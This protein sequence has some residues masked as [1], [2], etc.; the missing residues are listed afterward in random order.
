MKLLPQF[1]KNSVDERVPSIEM[2]NRK[3]A[4]QLPPALISRSSS[5]AQLVVKICYLLSFTIGI[6]GTY[7]TL[8]S[9][10]M[11]DTDMPSNVLYSLTLMSAGLLLDAA[12]VGESD[13]PVVP[14]L[15][16]INDDLMD[17]KSDSVIMLDLKQQDDNQLLS[18]IPNH[19]KIDQISSLND[20]NC[21]AKEDAKE[22]S[23]ARPASL[24]AIQSKGSRRWFMIGMQIFSVSWFGQAFSLFIRNAIVESSGSYLLPY[25]TLIGL[26]TGHLFHVC[27]KPARLW[28]IRDWLFA[29]RNFLTSYEVMAFIFLPP[30]IGRDLSTYYYTTAAFWNGFNLND[31]TSSI[32]KRLFR[33]N[34][35]VIE[36]DE[37]QIDQE[38]QPDITFLRRR[39]GLLIT[40]SGGV[41]T[42]ASI[43]LLRSATN[44]NNSFRNI[45]A[46]FLGAIGCYLLTY[47]LGVYLG[48]KIPPRYYKNVLETCTYLLIPLASPDL[49][50]LHFF[51]MVGGGLCGGI[52][53]YIIKSHYRNTLMVMRHRLNDIEKLTAGFPNVIKQLLE[54]PFPEDQ[55]LL[56]ARKNNFKIRLT[57]RLIYLIMLTTALATQSLWKNYQI[58]TTAIACA[59]ILPIIVDFLLPKYSPSIYNIDE[60]SRPSRL[61]YL[62]S[63]SL[64]YLIKV[65]AFIGLQ[66]TYDDHGNLLTLQKVKPP[67]AIFS[68]NLVYIAVCVFASQLGYRKYHGGYVPYFPSDEEIRKLSLLAQPKELKQH[69]SKD[70]IEH[71]NQPISLNYHLLQ[72]MKDNMKIKL[73]AEDKVSSSN[74]PEHV[75][76]KSSAENFCPHFLQRLSLFAI[77]KPL[78]IS[79]NQNGEL[80]S[81]P[82]ATF[83]CQDCKEDFAQIDVEFS[84]RSKRYTEKRFDVNFYTTFADAVVRGNAV[85]RQ[86]TFGLPAGLSLIDGV[87]SVTI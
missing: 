78:S 79:S 32:T 84:I 1:K 22:I 76:E 86:F 85:A 26:M 7:F 48:H 62:D 75:E 23:I 19:S 29:N 31:G 42:S 81:F 43:L 52:S 73:A 83:H 80:S 3:I 30:I 2:N 11:E 65:A 40:L 15:N 18:P 33:K 58:N 74:D 82:V 67:V 63:F 16:S 61:F 37:K 6:I 27:L 51:G 72:F 20:S 49:S 50:I 44:I 68:A 41:L 64:M 38:N 34:L 14:L 39:T 13:A 4:G 17:K 70:T 66:G 5:Y 24:E 8:R 56:S 71:K 21:D 57:S 25:T 87:K 46:M 60:M 9:Q 47:P 28:G 69:Y 54:L 36:T 10:T 12:R 35:Q 55:T 59:L 45:F 77:P 53:Y